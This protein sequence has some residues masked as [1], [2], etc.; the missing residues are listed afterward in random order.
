MKTAKKKE[1]TRGPNSPGLAS[2]RGLCGS[3]LFCG[4]KISTHP[5]KM[6]GLCG[7]TRRIRP[8]L[9]SLT[10][11]RKIW[12]DGG[13]LHLMHRGSWSLINRAK[14]QTVKPILAE[15]F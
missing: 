8:I 1:L 10:I 6:C 4:L 11:E 7:S 5:A 9:P 3:N 12:L 14:L 2:I 15:A 13:G